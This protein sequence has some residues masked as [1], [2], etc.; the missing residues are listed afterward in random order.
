MFKAT[1]LLRA[2]VRDKTTPARTAAHDLESFCWVFVLRAVQDALDSETRAALQRECRRIFAATSYQELLNNRA[3]ALP[4]D[5]C[6]AFDTIQELKAY[7][8]GA[9]ER[10]LS[11]CL[12]TYWCLLKGKFQSVRERRLPTHL[13][14]ATTMKDFPQTYTVTK[15][16]HKDLLKAFDVRAIK[17]GREAGREGGV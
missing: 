10:H 13:N 15:A 5:L 14:L 16:T 2:I 4:A 6:E 7:L 1:E 8:D 11:E 17:S 9:G 3:V 12:D